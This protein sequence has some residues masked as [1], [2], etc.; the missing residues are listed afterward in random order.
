MGA[1]FPRH[2]QLRHRH[3]RV[4]R[5][6]PAPQHRQ[7]SAA[8]GV[9]DQPRRR[10]RSGRMADHAL[11]PGRRDRCADDR[12]IRG[13]VSAASRD[14]RAGLGAHRLQRAHVPRSDVRTRRALTVARGSASR[15]VLRHR[16]ARGGRCTRAGQA[17]TG[18]RLRADRAHRRKRRRGSAR[19]LPRSASG[20]AGRL[21][22]CRGDLRRRHDRDRLLRSGPPR[23]PGSHPPPRAQS[24]QDRPSVAR[25]RCRR[26]RL[27]RILRRLQLRRTARHRSRRFPRVG[28]A[29]SAHPHG[30]RNDD[31]QPGR[32][33]PG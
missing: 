18:R 8:V 21:H 3:D 26:D 7:R 13:E 33:T 10:D 28:G 1:P 6:G 5:H 12:G 19:H 14:D 24:V 29:D 11:R 9:G 27:R 22:G 17:R 4:R 2:R 16:R 20:L 32:R 25:P 15:G 31:R 23:R 30:T